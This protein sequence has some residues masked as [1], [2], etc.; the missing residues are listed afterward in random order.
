[1]TATVETV[2]AEAKR[3][4]R[5]IRRPMCVAFWSDLSGQITFMGDTEE[6]DRLPFTTLDRAMG[7]LKEIEAKHT[8]VWIV[9][10]CGSGCCI[11]IKN[12]RLDF[13]IGVYSSVSN[14]VQRE[15]LAKALVWKLNVEYPLIRPAVG[16]VVKV[17]DDES[18]D[19]CVGYIVYDDKD[20]LPFK[21][22]YLVEGS[23][24]NYAWYAEEAVKVQGFRSPDILK[25]IQSIAINANIAKFLNI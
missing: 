4:G 24:S 20:D 22:A 14:M 8:G 12:T 21:V 25:R 2:L 6:D 17:A 7:H 11:N 13:E 5:S 1:M 10:E 16:N 15:A 18:E 19:E 23:Y 9:T 3:I